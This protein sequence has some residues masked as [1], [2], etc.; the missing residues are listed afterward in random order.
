MRKFNYK[1]AVFRYLSELAN[2]LNEEQIPIENIVKITDD[3][4]YQILYLKKIGE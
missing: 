3:Y 1:T 4:P 2:F